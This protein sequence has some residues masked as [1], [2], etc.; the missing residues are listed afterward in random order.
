MSDKNKNYAFLKSGM[1]KV[2]SLGTAS[3]A[4]FAKSMGILKKDMVEV[5]PGDLIQGYFAAHDIKDGK[6]I[7]DIEKAKEIAMDKWRIVRNQKLEKLDTEFIIA[8]EVGDKDEKT[9]IVDEKNRLRNMTKDPE[10]VKISTF[11][12]LLN[13]EPKVLSAHKG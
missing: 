4:D 2:V 12:E 7:C 13:Y 8:L 10:F 1:F 9:E 6:I 3:A 5:P 11:K